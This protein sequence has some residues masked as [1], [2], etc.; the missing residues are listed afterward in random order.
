MSRPRCVVDTNVLISAGLTSTGTPRRVVEWILRHGQ[1]LASP[2]TLSELSSRFLTR[3]K[4][5]HYASPT[6]RAFFVRGISVNSELIS[7][8]SSLAVSPDPDDNQFIELAV[9]GGADCIVTGNTRDFPDQYGG[10]PVLT[11]AAFADRYLG[12]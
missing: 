9:D 2:S 12:G 11:P 6:D 7:V 5:D 1:L 10:I 3:T 4:F 8:T